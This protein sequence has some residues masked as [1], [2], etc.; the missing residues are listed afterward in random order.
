MNR[1]LSF[2]LA[3][4][5]RSHLEQ[6][7]ERATHCRFN[8]E[9]ALF[10]EQVEHLYSVYDHPAR[11]DDSFV[12]DVFVT[13]SLEQM[14]GLIRKVA[15]AMG[16]RFLS[17]SQQDLF[18]YGGVV[19]PLSSSWGRPAA[20]DIASVLAIGGGCG[21]GPQAQIYD[22]FRSH[23]ELLGSFDTAT[24]EKIGPH[25]TLQTAR[26]D[27]VDKPIPEGERP[28]V[29]ACLRTLDKEYYGGYPADIFA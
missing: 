18:C 6:S 22:F 11:R 14:H 3:S 28:D 15:S 25:L 19:G 7:R 5:A 26:R 27:L 8:E 17:I 16:V 1:R 12:Q 20:W 21:N 23:P 13:T 2:F 9:R 4:T 24:A 29:M 10:W